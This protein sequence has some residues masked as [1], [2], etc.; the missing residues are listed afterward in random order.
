VPNHAIQVTMVVQNCS[1][2]DLHIPRGTKMGVLENI[3]GERILPM[4]GKKIVEQINA[5]K[6][7]PDNLPKPLSPAEQKEFLKKLN[8]N[9]PED[10]QKLYEQIILA[11]H[12]V[13]SKTKDDLGKANNFKHKIFTK[14]D[15]PVFQKQY[16]IP[17]MHREYLE[18]QV[19]EWLKLGIVQPS[20]S[21]Y[22]SPMFLVP[23]KDGGVRVV[24]DFR[25]LNANS[26]DDRYSMK[27]INECIGHI[28]RAGSTIF[29]TLDLT[30]GF[31]H[32]SARVSS[33]FPK[34]GRGRNEW[35]GK[36]H[37]VHR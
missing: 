36:H 8:L 32:G 16:P 21:R 30:S 14:T 24:Q 17:E 27:N 37:S 7:T 9:V 33:Q 35:V 20:K 11:N 23:K 4:D 12:D 22:N 25:A 2:T 19:Q 29:S 31:W 18:K 3:H 15:E 1:P 6:S 28:G 5:S 13:F 26:H 34:N 10:E